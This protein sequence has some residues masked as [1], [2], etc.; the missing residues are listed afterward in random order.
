MEKYATEKTL[1]TSDGTKIHLLDNKPHSFEHAAIQ[2][3]KALKKKDEYFI[4]G[5]QYDKEKCN[6][7][8]SNKD[9]LPYYKTSSFKGARV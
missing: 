5:V 2:Y 9:S 6:E 1:T 8:R 7:L 3:P 4:Y